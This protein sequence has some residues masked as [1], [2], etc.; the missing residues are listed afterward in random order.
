MNTENRNNV[1]LKMIVGKIL[2]AS[3]YG[4]MVGMV[5]M[6]GMIGMLGS[7]G[8]NM[9]YNIEYR[10][11]NIHISRCLRQPRHRALAGRRQNR[12]NEHILNFIIEHFFLDHIR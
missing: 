1:R 3:K 7:A 5:W 8:R 11:Y 2:D 9:T 4:G 6:V 10:M 12:V